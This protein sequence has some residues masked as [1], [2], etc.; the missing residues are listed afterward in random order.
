MI[1]QIYA[2]GT[3]KQ[4]SIE[5][6]Q[7][8]CIGFGLWTHSFWSFKFAVPFGGLRTQTCLESPVRCPCRSRAS[9]CRAN[10]WWL[11]ENECIESI[12]KVSNIKIKWERKKKPYQM[13]K[14]HT[15]S[16][17]RSP[18]HPSC[19]P[20]VPRPSSSLGDVVAVVVVECKQMC[21]VTDTW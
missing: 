7:E 19:S 3:I 2:F 6:V 14:S 5:Q 10:G 17:G 18:R 20:I 9:C 21:D 11:S 13:P 15:T 16:L 12:K 8:G 1:T 4:N